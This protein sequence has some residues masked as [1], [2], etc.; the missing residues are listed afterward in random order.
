MLDARARELVRQL[1]LRLPA[2]AL[3][4]ALRLEQAGVRHVR[5][6][7][8]LLRLLPQRLDRL[9]SLL[10]LAQHRPAIEENYIPDV[11]R[12]ARIAPG[13]LATV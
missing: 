2:R 6:R 9:L 8:Q 13:I 4:V 1:D 11:L 5:P 7:A 3:E 12:F 10:A